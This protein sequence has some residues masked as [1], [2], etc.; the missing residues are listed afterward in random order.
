M[1]RFPQNI[2]ELR[3][4]I[5]HVATRKFLIGVSWSCIWKFAGFLIKLCR[6]IPVLQNNY[7]D[8]HCYQHFLFFRWETNLAV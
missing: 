6:D 3:I 2:L 8:R 4:L 5:L 1:S 7:T